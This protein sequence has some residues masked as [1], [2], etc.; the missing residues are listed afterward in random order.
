[1]PV[2]HSPLR[3][4]ALAALRSGRVSVIYA[5]T[6]HDLNIV[7]VIGRVLSS[8]PGGARYAVDF[9]DG[10]W[11]CTCTVSRDSGQCSHTFAVQLVTTGVTA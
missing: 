7:Q 2:D 11:R 1:M 6:D 3:K 4:S 10:D 5:R 8:R 9:R